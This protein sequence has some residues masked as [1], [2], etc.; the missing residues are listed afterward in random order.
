MSAGRTS[1]LALVRALPES[2]LHYGA[3]ARMS[4]DEWQEEKER[5]DTSDTEVLFHSPLRLVN[6][7]TER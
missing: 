3:E 6:Y 1:G 4:R 2:F 5:R 7:A